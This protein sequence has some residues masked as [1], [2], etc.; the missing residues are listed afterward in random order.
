MT[1]VKLFISLTFST[2][3][4]RKELKRMKRLSEKKGFP[5]GVR[6]YFTARKVGISG[7]PASYKPLISSALKP[8]S[9]IMNSSILPQRFLS[10]SLACRLNQFPIFTLPG[11]ILVAGPFLREAFSPFTRHKE[12]VPVSLV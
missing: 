5:P 7:L 10:N 1:S 8:R 2:D 12:V 4:I 6:D 3:K 9:Q 11:S